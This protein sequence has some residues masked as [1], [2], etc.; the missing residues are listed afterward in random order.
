MP[1]I[2][3]KA[4]AVR[5]LSYWTTSSYVCDNYYIYDYGYGYDYEFDSG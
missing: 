5:V 1:V 3:A 2:A 4:K